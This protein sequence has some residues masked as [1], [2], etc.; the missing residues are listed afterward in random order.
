MILTF[1]V[2]GI[3]APKGSLRHVGHG[4]LVE[5]V[6]A[7]RPWMTKVRAAALT[8]AAATGWRHDGGAV[9][10]EID[11]VIPRP[12]TV[13]R[14]LPT[15]RSSGD[16]DKLERA[17]LDALAAVRPRGKRPGQAGVLTDDSVVVDLA[18]TKRYPSGP[19]PFVGARITITEVSA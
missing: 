17:V 11:F 3:P 1:A 9:R 13:R 8:A 10:V 5:Q 4:R 2:H 6:V 12:K 18:A 7:S 14:A 16:T 15:T 19:A